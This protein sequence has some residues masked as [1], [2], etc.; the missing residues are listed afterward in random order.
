M[1]QMDILIFASQTSFI[2]IFWLGYFFFAKT[3]LPLVS[4]ELKLKQKII[5][6]NIR[7]FRNNIN[8]VLFFRLP[9]GKLLVKTRGML[10]SAESLVTKKR[11][12]FGI[13]P[14]DLLFLKQKSQA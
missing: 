2:F 5:L 12:F 11:V 9:H 1:P 7:W 3:I 13:Y 6:T 4:L 10:L 8:R 14:L